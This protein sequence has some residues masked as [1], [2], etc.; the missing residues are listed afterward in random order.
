NHL[1]ELVYE[2][3]KRVKVLPSDLCSDADFVRRV[4]I[5][6][7]GLPP[8]PDVVRS[9]LAGTRPTQK[10]RDEMIDKLVGSPEY[11][12]QW[13][14]KWADM[15]QVNR[16]FLGDVGAK[17]LRDYIRK[18]VA[19]NKPYDQFAYEV[20]TGTGSNAEHPAAA[21]FKILRE[22]D[23]AM[24]NTTHL[25][26]AIRFNCNKCHDHPFER[27]TQGQYYHMA[28]FFAQ[29]QRQEDP[30]FKGQRTQGTDVRGA[31]PLVE[32]VSDGN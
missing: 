32:I 5:D 21:Y 1:D 4:Y 3:L 31:L 19:D 8:E 18:A 16:K 26:L 23:T 24:E 11:V 29:I 13:T 6:L 10:K 15:L 2:K 7:T 25:F 28:A 30:K 27:W 9:F 22:P 20:L 12:E 17:A 14:N